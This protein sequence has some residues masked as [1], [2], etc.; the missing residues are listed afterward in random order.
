M[1][2]LEMTWV[3]ALFGIAIILLGILGLTRPGS[4]IRLVQRSWQSQRGFY[5]GIGIRVV[6][7]LVLFMAASA[8]RFPEAF[9]ILG[10]I[11]VVAAM[12][13]PF[14]GFVRLQGFVQWWTRKSPGVIRGWSL[15]TAALGVFLF[16]GAM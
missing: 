3:V 6:F 7:G 9:R 8:S 11:S 14:V 10:I 12:V 13:A 1:G 16:Y 5:F 4:L 15:V 2:E